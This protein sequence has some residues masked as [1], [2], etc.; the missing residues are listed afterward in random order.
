M[1]RAHPY[2][3]ACKLYEDRERTQHRS[4]PHALEKAAFPHRH[5]Y[6]L[7]LPVPLEEAG[8][9]PTTPRTCSWR[10]VELQNDKSR[11]R[12]TLTPSPMALL[13]AAHAK[14]SVWSHPEEELLEEDSVRLWP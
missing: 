3:D 11:P 13:Q 12:K 10:Q 5:E 6:Q 9:A 7:T 2:K 1:E 4:P 14:P 8:F